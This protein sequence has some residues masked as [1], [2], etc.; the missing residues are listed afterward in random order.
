MYV[1][2]V[3]VR[4]CVCVCTYRKCLRVEQDMQ[5]VFGL[6]Q[7]AARLL[8][9]GLRIQGKRCRDSIIVCA[10]FIKTFYRRHTHIYRGKIKFS[11][12]VNWDRHEAPPEKAELCS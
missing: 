6:A 4:A 7:L 2:D 5:E 1:L 11:C 8:L 3:R 9:S 10:A 12:K